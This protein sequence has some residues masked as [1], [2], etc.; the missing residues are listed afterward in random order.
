MDNEVLA[1][2]D[3][4][5]LG[6]FTNAVILDTVGLNSPVSMQYYPLPPDQLVTNYAIPCNLDPRPAARL[7]GLSRGLRKENTI[8]QRPVPIRVHPGRIIAHGYLR[9][10]GNVDLSPQQV[11][12]PKKGL[13]PGVF[14]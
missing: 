4:G 9:Q 10:S 3:V 1:A 5:V 13:I 12:K 7:A 11:T 6:Y 8:N 2:G 14:N